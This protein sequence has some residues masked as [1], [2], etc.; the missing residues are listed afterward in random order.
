LTAT[1]RT[2]VSSPCV[3]TTS[4]IRSFRSCSQKVRPLVR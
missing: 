1:V 3:H 2:I 4:G